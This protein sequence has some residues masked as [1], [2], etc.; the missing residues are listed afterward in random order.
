MEVLWRSFQKTIVI[1]ATGVE[2]FA[3]SF[4]PFMF[5]KVVSWSKL[6]I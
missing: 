2:T 1:C 3:V 4:S 6:S 5:S